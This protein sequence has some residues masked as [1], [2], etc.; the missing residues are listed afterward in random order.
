MANTMYRLRHNQITAHEVVKET[1]HRITFIETYVDWR[2]GES[3]SRTV[4]ENKV[5]S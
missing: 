5:S 1:D 3:Q 4:S 2:S